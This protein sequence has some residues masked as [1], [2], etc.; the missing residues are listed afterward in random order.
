MSR[1]GPSK[2]RSMRL[3]GETRRLLAEARALKG[4]VVGRPVSNDV[5]IRR[6]LG[7][8]KRRCRVVLKRR[9][10]STKDLA[11]VQRDAVEKYTPN[12]VERTVDISQRSS[13]YVPRVDD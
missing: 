1:P 3:S 12:N 9:G 4:L 10:W 2:P 8:L 11:K 5:V 7:N 13:S 6:A